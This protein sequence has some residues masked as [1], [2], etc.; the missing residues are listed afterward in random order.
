MPVSTDTAGYL[1]KIAKNAGITAGGQLLS[2]VLGPITGIITTRA[3]GAEL[4]GIYTLTTYW[5]SM[6]ADF[7]TLGFAGMLNR[8][9]ASY[10]GEGRLDKAKGAILLSLKI[11][12]IA[13]SILA[14]GLA[15]FAEPFCR[16]VIKQ[17]EYATAFR[18]V[19]IAILFTALYSIFIAALNGLQQQ[20]YVVLTNAV[21]ANLTK[22]ISL[23][24]L[25]VFGFELYA[26]L[27]SSLLQDLIVLILAGTFLLKVFPGLRERSLPATTEKKR[28]WKF[29][30]TLFATSLFNKHTFQL[31]VVFLGMFCQPLEVGL[32]AVALRLQPL[33]YMP[34][35][36]IMQIFGPI[37]AEL[38]A[39][40]QHNEMADIYKTVTK[41]TTSFSLPIFLTIILYY[42]PLLNIFGKDF[43]G[44]VSALL[45][46]SV[47]N[48]CADMLGMSGQ[49]L[50]MIGKPG[51]N[52]ANSIVITVINIVLYLTLIPSYGIV[53]AALAHAVSMICINTLRLLQVYYFEKMHPFK[54]SFYKPALAAIFSVLLV[55]FSQ[56]YAT[57]L[58]GLWVLQLLL[59]WLVYATGVWI[60]RLDKND[61]TV[62]NAIIGRFRLGKFS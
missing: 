27:A 6:L 1:K 13:G 8:F 55:L 51:V 10:K 62:V 19:S 38:H 16:Y 7:S 54:I 57:I 60:L 12:F 43:H 28:L 20:G 26:A 52:L 9:S 33:I 30:S 25:L 34:H 35:T 50:T 17:P 36:A 24:V 29:S 47:G 3:L 18:F 2:Q 5:T 56:S 31:D 39:R 53:G 32:Y 37:V 21:V 41:W 59:F 49:V 11:A 61:L 45:I 48:F 44:A 23:V 22:L 42:E 40:R 4:Y 14:L 46:L 15:L 58:D